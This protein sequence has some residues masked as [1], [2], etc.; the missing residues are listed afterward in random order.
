M[1]FCSCYWVFGVTGIFWILIF[2]QIYDLHIF[3]SHSV[4][5]FDLLIVCFELWNFK[6]FHEVQ[7]VYFCCCLHLWR[8]NQEI[9]AK[10]TVMKLLSY[11]FF[12]E[13]FTVL[14]LTFKCLIHFD[15]I[16][17]T[18]LG[19][20]QNLV[21]CMWIASSPGTICWKD[22]PFP[23]KLFWYPYQ[24]LSDHIYKGLFLGC[25]FYSIGL[26]LCLFLCQ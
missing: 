11:F 2:S 7:F 18:L 12:S 15:L 6:I 13:T 22:C 8:H 3:F 5:V 23:T 24:I 9:I 10:S 4:V 14:G 19:K 17:Y 16:S 20:G 25:L 1:H 26:S 21:F